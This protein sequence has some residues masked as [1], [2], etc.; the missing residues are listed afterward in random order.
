[1]SDVG[2]RSDS[3][4]RG[5]TRR[6][7]KWSLGA[8]VAVVG[9]ALLLS[10][11][12]WQTQSDSDA[13]S[14]DSAIL[15]QGPLTPDYQMDQTLHD[16]LPDSVKASGT[17]RVATL[18]TDAPIVFKTDEGDLNGA[19][20][21][22]WQAFEQI[23]GVTIEPQVYSNTGAELTALD[24]GQVDIVWGSDGDTRAREEKYTFV[25]YFAP[26]YS[27]Y[28]QKGNPENI[29]SAADICGKTYAGIKGAVSSSDQ[30]NRYCAD[31]GLDSVTEHQF[32]DSG[33][34]L[35]G[36]ASGQAQAWIYFDYFGIWQRA[37]GTP[38]E[39][40]PVDDQFK[41][42]LAFGVVTPKT[43]PA[44]SETF[45]K[46]FQQLKSDGYYDKVLERWELSDLAIEPGINVGDRYSLFG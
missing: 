24:S 15:T 37:Q 32:D 2:T 21:D 35:L 41:E 23:L 31:Q 29:Q 10:G 6:M 44:Y 20:V 1:M 34:A 13:E 7:R 46:V 5:M 14:T 25:D 19:V 11:C 16:A 26:S 30:L 40:L 4:I 12:S 18:G 8:V 27:I 45:L 43:E 9:G 3:G 42:S 36:V 33:A 28:V 22:F 17:L 39:I 38:I